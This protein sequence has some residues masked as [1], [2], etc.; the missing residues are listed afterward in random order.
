MGCGRYREAGTE[1]SYSC[2]VGFLLHGGVRAAVLG[3][4][5]VACVSW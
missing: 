2:P 3:K 4:S 1:L 5:V